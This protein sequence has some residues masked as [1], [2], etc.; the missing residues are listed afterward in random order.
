M[1]RP[2]DELRHPALAPGRGAP[3]DR[4]DLT[5]RQRLGVVLQ[6]AGLAEDGE[7]RVL[8]AGVIGDRLEGDLAGV[9]HSAGDV[10]GLF[11]RFV[12][13]PDWNRARQYAQTDHQCREATNADHNQDFAID[14]RLASLRFS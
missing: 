4:A 3:V 12:L 6:A 8:F 9:C 14:A 11:C 1:N 10:S 13:G 5:D 2:A 7:Q